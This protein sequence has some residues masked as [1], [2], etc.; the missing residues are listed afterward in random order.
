MKLKESWGPRKL[1]LQI[2]SYYPY[3]LQLFIT[4]AKCTGLKCQHLIPYDSVNDSD[5][6]RNVSIGQVDI[7]GQFAIRSDLVFGLC[8]EF[9][10]QF[11][12]FTRIFYTCL[13]QKHDEV[14]F[15]LDVM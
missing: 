14:T 13:W 3:T 8:K 4:T 15:H 12:Y 11:L 10:D 7:F 1:Q 6:Q 9:S 5:P 2:S